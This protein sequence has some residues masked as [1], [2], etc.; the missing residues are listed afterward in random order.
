MI[1]AVAK[2]LVYF[3]RHSGCL[4]DLFVVYFKCLN[5]SEII[6][7]KTSAYILYN[8]TYGFQCPFLACN[9]AVQY[10]AV[11]LGNDVYFIVITWTHCMH[12]CRLAAI[13]ATRINK[14]YIP[15]IEAHLYADHCITTTLELI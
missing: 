6:I 3:Y 7:C 9:L 13:L 4:S 1:V 8:G 14:V 2:V 12:A 10:S 5:Y 11:Y 15:N